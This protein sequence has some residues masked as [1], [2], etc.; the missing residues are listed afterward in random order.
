MQRIL[1]ILG[2]EVYAAVL[3]I[4]QSLGNVRTDEAKYL[5]NIPY[6]HPPLA[7][8]ILSL[9]ESFPFQEFFWRIAFASFIVQAAWL[10]WSM[11]KDLAKHER[12]MLCACWLLS[13]AVIFQAGSIMMAPLTGLQGLLF[14]W[15]WVRSDFKSRHLGGWIALLWMVSVFTAYQGALLFPL[16]I[17]LLRRAKFSWLSTIFITGI[18]F[19]LLALYTLVNPLSLASL[20]NAGTDNAGASLVMILQEFLATWAIGGSVVLLI[21]GVIGLIW[22]RQ[23]LLL[24][25]FALISLYNLASVHLYYAILFT[26]FLMAGCIPI[27]QRKRALALPLF[28]LTVLG[29]VLLWFP[30][31]PVLEPGPARSMMQALQVQP[32]AGNVLL[33]WSFGH[34]WQYE[35]PVPV[36]RFTVEGL[37]EAQ[38]VICQHAC[39]WEVAQSGDF[40]EVAKAPLEV[41]QKR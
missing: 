12:T 8:W 31:H 23:W 32:G 26:P 16:V 41:W 36:R 33:D 24:G 39:P 3:A 29:S 21:A 13:A 30:F 18:P 34:E 10:V 35:S 11:A 19:A 17:G 4:L 40:T 1:I 27:L 7:R 9:T 2:L 37:E 28:G 25:T 20:V 14:V 22:H 15:L 38:A 6:P 5:L